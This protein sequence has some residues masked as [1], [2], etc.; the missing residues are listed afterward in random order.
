MSIHRSPETRP[1]RFKQIL[2]VDKDEAWCLVMRDAVAR[3]GY[4]AIVPGTLEEAA[5]ILRS[6]SP[7]LVLVSCLLDGKG[8]EFL[9]AEMDSLK[10]PPPVILVGYRD[11]DVQWEPWKSNP[12]VSILRQPFKTQDVLQIVRTLLA[13]TW[14]D[15]SQTR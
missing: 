3:G 8:A 5:R 4:C 7:D 9:G 1:V 14:D 15:A 12:R 10:A 13:S 11:S 6:G 2:I